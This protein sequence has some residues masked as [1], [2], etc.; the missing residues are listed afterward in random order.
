MGKNGKNLINQG[1]VFWGKTC[2]FSPFL[3]FRRGRK[4]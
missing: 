4:L 2:L 3:I 1:L